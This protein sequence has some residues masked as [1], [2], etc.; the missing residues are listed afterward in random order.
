MTAAVVDEVLREHPELQVTKHGADQLRMQAF[1]W[2]TAQPVDPETVVAVERK[3]VLDLDSGWTVSGKVDLA[4]LEGTDTL[5]ILDLKSLG[6]RPRMSPSPTSISSCACI[7]CWCC[8]GSPWKTP[9]E[10]QTPGI[11]IPV[12]GNPAEWQCP[13]CGGR[14]YTE[15]RLSPIGDGINYVRPRLVYPRVLR[16][17]GELH[18]RPETGVLTRAQVADFRTD[19]ERDAEKISRALETGEWPAVP[20]SHCSM[21]PC[22]AECPLPEQLRGHAGTVTTVEEAARALEWADREG[23]EVAAKKREARR[24]VETHGPVGGVRTR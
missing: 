21:C 5:A 7:R 8:S 10:C 23:A 22:P 20:G 15:Q 12:N 13:N 1:H 9:C 6:R 24:F 3:F 16:Q 14:G 11:A 4:A 19:V 2:A 18:R 17:D